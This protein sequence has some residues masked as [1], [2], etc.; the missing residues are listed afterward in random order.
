MRDLTIDE[1]EDVY[2]ARGCGRPKKLKKK[3]AHRRKKNCG[4]SSNEAPDCAPPP[5]K[6]D[7]VRTCLPTPP[8]CDVSTE[9]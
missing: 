3:V 9:A 5:S 1:L 7:V 6:C 8:P 2:G 4:N